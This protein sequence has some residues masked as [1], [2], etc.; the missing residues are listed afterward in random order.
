M[1][2]QA[3]ADGCGKEQFVVFAAMEGL[4]E[5]CG[6]VDGQQG[7]IDLGGDAGLLAEMSEVGGEAVAQ[8]EGGGGH[9][10]ALEPEA[11]TDAR[12]RI[13]VRGEQRFQ[14]FGDEGRV[15]RVR[16]GL[17]QLGQACES[18]GG[19]A[20]SAGDVEQIAG[21]RAGAEQRV[22]LGNGAD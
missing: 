8:V 18:G 10:V 13:E 2:G 12:L 11:L 21:A 6:C 9:A 22:A 19:S 1:E 3:G 15:R 20:E 7:R 17:G 14:L 5:G 16:L 4:G